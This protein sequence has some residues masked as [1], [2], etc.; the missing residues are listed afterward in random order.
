MTAPLRRV[1][2]LLLIAVALALAGCGSNVSPSATGT[3]R[4][5]AAPVLTPVPG[6]PSPT[7]A[8][9]PPPTSIPESNPAVGPIWD[10]LPASWP[11][12]PGQSESE[13]GT[14]AS[15]MLVVKG[16]A[17]VLARQLAAALTQLGWTVDVGSPLED[18][19]VVLEATHQP[20]GC[21]AQAQLFGSHDGSDD[22]T[23]VVYYGAGCPFG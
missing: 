12:L 2:P 16:D 20:V 9:T 10:G 5:S 23:E 4:T 1:A 6:A 17:Q 21:R 7:P 19:S 14:D 3:A 22:G 11:T 15:T 13:I 8:P 18:G